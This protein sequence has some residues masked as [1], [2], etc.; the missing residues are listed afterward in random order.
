MKRLFR[1]NNPG[2][3]D[4]AGLMVFVVIYLAAVALLLLPA[5]TLT[6]FAATSVFTPVR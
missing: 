1:S 5:E 3:A 6:G 4:Y 2:L